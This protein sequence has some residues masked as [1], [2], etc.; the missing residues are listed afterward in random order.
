MLKIVTLPT[1]S[2]RERSKEVD[3][4]LLMT[5][6]MQK[7][8]DEMVPMMHKSDGVGLAAP[9]VGKNMRVCVIAKLA[10]KKLTED[11]ILI[12]PVW[13]KISK[14]KNVDNEGCLSVPNIFGKVTRYSDVHVTAWNRFGEIISFEAHKFFARVIQHESDHLNGVLFID[15]AK[16]LYTVEGKKNAKSKI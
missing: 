7:F 3:R 14:K 12:N 2:L 5:E 8:I 6:E 1:K 13:E 9:Q 4:D 16:D 11:L 10:D 15:K